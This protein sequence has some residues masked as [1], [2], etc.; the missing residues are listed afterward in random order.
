MSDAFKSLADIHRW[1]C[2]TLDEGDAGRLCGML[3]EVSRHINGLETRNEELW[4][5]ACDLRSNVCSIYGGEPCSVLCQGYDP[6]TYLC[7]YERRLRGLGIE[8]GDE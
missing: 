1:A 7:Y 2:E 3:S 6:G 4:K 5:L 8:V